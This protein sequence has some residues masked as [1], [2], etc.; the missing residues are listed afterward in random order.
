MRH[1]AYKIMEKNKISKESKDVQTA[2][3][4]G[5]TSTDLLYYESG[6]FF[7]KYHEAFM[8]TMGSLSIILMVMAI[9]LVA[10]KCFNKI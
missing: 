5:V 10:L 4:K 6:T 7:R 2:R 3:D 1:L 8:I 9:I